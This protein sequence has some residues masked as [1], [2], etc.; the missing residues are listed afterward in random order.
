MQKERVNYPDIVRILS[1]IVP[2]ALILQAVAWLRW[3]VDVPFWD[4]WRTI[5]NDIG[6]LSFS[7]I[8]RPAN[9]TLSPIGKVL[10]SLAVRYLAYNAIGYQLLSMIV[11][12][13]G[14]VAVKFALIRR[15]VPN[16]W[17][18]LPAFISCIFIIQPGS[19]WG[20]QSLA[21]HQA[22]PLL[23]LLLCIILT[24]KDNLSDAVRIVAISFFGVVAGF[25]YVSGA[26]AMLAAA[27]VTL[28]AA[29]RS[30]SSEAKP[31][32]HAA[33]GY[34]FAS[35]ITVPAQ[36]WVILV[37]QSGH[38]HASDATWV[39]PWQWEFWAFVLG[40]TARS[41]RFPLLADN[42]VISL[43]V[44]LVIFSV[45]VT[46]ALWAISAIMLPSRYST[47]IHRPSY[48]YLTLFGAVGIYTLM[49][50]A[51]RASLDA[52]PLQ[53]W[54][55]YFSR[56]G[57]RFHFF[58]ITILI[59]WAAILW[60]ER[61]AAWIGKR[62][63]IASLAV[64]ALAL[65]YAAV[66]GIFSFGAYF[67][68][69]AMLRQRPGFACMQEKVARGDPVI[70]GTIYPGDLTSAIYAAR[71]WDLSFTRYLHFPE[72]EITLALREV[73]GGELLD[74]DVRRVELAGKPDSQLYF[75][76]GAES[77]QDF[78]QCRRIRLTGVVHAE[79]PDL[80]QMFYL[81]EGAAAYSEKA[82]TAVQYPKGT[83]A[84]ELT[85]VSLQGFQPQLRLDPG[86]AAQP[87]IVERLS[88]TCQ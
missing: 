40:M 71:N 10:D 70:C 78:S 21:Y 85:A 61:V 47:S 51:S 65:I 77:L 80:I 4:D 23:M 45:L 57:G 35:L 28:I 34:S 24:F 18:A 41:V 60:G 1:C 36:L 42:L 39:L 31:L 56:G 58:W 76:V 81:E 44:S 46:A 6:S 15:L 14:I 54:G 33:A 13:G 88:L 5:Q 29:A 79:Q 2:L 48:V 12:L 75:D 37:Y 27:G 19:Y 55:N 84:F 50:A 7:D 38:I 17:V 72:R 32:W 30:P 9:D 69:E 62:Q 22:I 66:A 73:L 16:P 68:G 8:F 20:L 63:Y 25:S 83:F 82:S 53:G 59:P 74:G 86:T 52:N 87:Y 3:G 11:C 64:A 26:M 67:H 43:S 49:V